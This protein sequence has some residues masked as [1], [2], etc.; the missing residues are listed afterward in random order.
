MALPRIFVIDESEAVRETLSVVLGN[1]GEVREL[2]PNDCRPTFPLPDADPQLLIVD[3]ESAPGPLL[4][5]ISRNVC[6]V[7]WLRSDPRLG[8]PVASAFQPSVVLARQ[9]D[10]HA[11]RGE[12]EQLLRRRHAPPQPPARLSET[13]AF[14]YLTHEAATVAHEATTNHLPVLICGEPGTGRARVAAALPGVVAGTRFVAMSP[15]NCT[16]EAVQQLAQGGPHVTLFVDDVGTAA[17]TAQDVLLDLAEAG[18]LSTVDG[19]LDVRLITATPLSLS[20]LATGG[21][22]SRELFYRLSVL[23]ITLPP[24]RDRSE[25]IPAL[26]KALAA[27]LCSALGCPPVAFTPR[28]MQ[29]LRRYLWF[30]NTAELEAVLAR[31]ISLAHKEVLDVDD[32]LF[33]FGR[34]TPQPTA[35]PKV[36]EPAAAP[37]ATSAVDLIIGELAHEFKNPL[38]TI[39]TF[40]QHL[41]RLLDEESG[42]GQL[43]RL[44]GEAVDRMDR[45]LENLLQFTRF[46]TPVARS[47]ALGALIGPVLAELGPLLSERRLVLDYRPSH[48]GLPV[49]VDPEQ[50]AYALTNLLRA[51]IRGLHDGA[52]IG[53][54]CLEGGTLSI[55]LPAT[56]GDL[57]AKLRTLLSDRYTA[58]E[59]EPVLPLGVALARSLI[60]RNG[61][62]FDLREGTAGSTVSVGLPV[63]AELGRVTREHG[64]TTNSDR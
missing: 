4:Q 11:L 29:R 34:L 5:A 57:I 61:G 2:A 6:P 7:V 45:A 58:A 56:E 31:S 17:A 10:A 39:K 54:S 42:N 15:Q 51:L 50:I 3:A 52:S 64:T 20:G 30:G 14:P 59:S 36:A 13:L 26:A 41:D 53:V 60:I 48:A 28:A 62:R 21:Q 47:V 55:T 12:V 27:D 19:W 33:G 40:A 16:R 63:A 8:A 23:P 22:L 35:A 46:E 44:T 43:A 25:D 9:F 37:L 24:L 1:L 38:V 32:L 49:A 18:G